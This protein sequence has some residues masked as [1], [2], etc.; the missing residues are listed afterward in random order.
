VARLSD[1]ERA[2]LPDRAFASIDSAGVRRL[3]IN[4][5]AHVRNA[6]ARFGRTRFET[7]EARDVARQ[8]LLRAAKRF[9]IMPLGFVSTQLK[10]ARLGPRAAATLPSGQVTFLL[11]DIEGSTA[12]LQELDSHYVTLLDDLR[13]LICTI[14]EGFG[15][16]RVDSHGDEYF[17]VFEQPAAA[18][19]AAVALQLDLAQR[20]WP[21]QASVR[22]RAGIHTGRPTLTESGYVGLSVHTVARIGSVAHGGQVVVFGRTRLALEELPE[23]I[24]LLSLGPHRLAGLPGEEELFQLVAPGL[25]DTFPPLRILR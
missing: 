21:C 2:L 16:R 6:L 11:T 8:R 22:V 7:E 13:S 14:A 3:P 23:G 10:S 18:L 9:G 15:G 25:S 4:D 17:T 20:S 1:R 12:L 19:L 5:E 24:T